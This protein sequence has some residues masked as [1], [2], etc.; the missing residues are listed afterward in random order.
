MAIDITFDGQT[1]KNS[2]IGYKISCCLKPNVGF[3]QEFYVYLEL[4]R[5]SHEKSDFYS[6][7]KGSSPHTGDLA[8]LG[9]FSEVGPKHEFSNIDLQASHLRARQNYKTRVLEFMYRDQFLQGQDESPVKLDNSWENALED[10]RLGDEYILTLNGRTD[11]LL[12]LS[13]RQS[14]SGLQILR[15]AWYSNHENSFLKEILD[16]RNTWSS[17]AFNIGSQDFEIKPNDITCVYVD[18]SFGSFL[19]DPL[20][21]VLDIYD[22]HSSNSHGRSL[23]QLEVQDDTAH[24]LLAAETA[25][26]NTSSVSSNRI[27]ETVTLVLSAPTYAQMEI[28]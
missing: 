25:D 18:H 23:A 15:L 5:A 8:F 19:D 11:G 26:Q 14:Y 28:E 2:T 24:G 22:K 27:V 16:R 13:F 12:G 17:L 21:S 6:I 10:N 20:P 9:Q 1:T 3:K 7:R 4:E